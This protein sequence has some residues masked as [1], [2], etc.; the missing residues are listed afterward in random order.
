MCPTMQRNIVLAIA[1]WLALASV[2]S[3]AP[4]I[5]E[6][7]PEF[8]LTDAEGETHNLADYRGK[9]VVLE[10]LNHDCPFVQKYYSSGRMQALQ[11]QYTEEDVIWLVINTSAPG[12]QGHLSAEDAQ[13]ISREKKAAHTALLL[14][15]DGKVGRAY[16]AKV[17]PH[18]F[19]INS[20]GILVYNGAIDSIKS[21]DVADL[22]RAENFVVSALSASMEGEPVERAVTQ[23]Y[24]C[25]I[26]Y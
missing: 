15:H 23:P 9:H 13:R 24:G 19:V 3:A 17:T 1:G 2:L 4:E 16:D 22:D 7:A 18:M 26:K 12:T 20:E 11:K 5:G 10:W 21:A 6:K 14:D 25:A 8:T